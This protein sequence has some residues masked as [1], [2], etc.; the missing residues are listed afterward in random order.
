LSG[1]ARWK[2]TLDTLAQVRTAQPTGA[3]CDSGAVVG[4]TVVLWPRTAWLAAASHCYTDCSLAH[5]CGRCLLCATTV[6]GGGRRLLRH[7]GHE[8]RPVELGEGRPRGPASAY[9]RCRGTTPAPPRPAPPFAGLA[10]LQPLR[11]QSCV[12]AVRGPGLVP[13]RAVPRRSVRQHEHGRRALHRPHTVIGTVLAGQLVARPERARGG[14]QHLVHRNAR[15]RAPMIALPEPSG[16]SPAA[17][18]R[19]V[20]AAAVRYRVGTGRHERARVRARGFQGSGLTLV[21]P[22]SPLIVC[23]EWCGARAR[24]RARRPGPVA[25]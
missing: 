5:G 4:V 23:A 22:Q 16:A 6:D 10:P 11:S 18:V 12:P 3:A 17:A 21:G 24:E 20:V 19:A 14:S 2:P 1:S 9:T 8:P 7:A 13:S 25:P 15:R